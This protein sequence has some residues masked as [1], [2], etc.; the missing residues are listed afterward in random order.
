MIGVME[1]MATSFKRTYATMPQLPRLLYS[2]LLPPWQ[3]TVDVCLCQRLLDT[4]KPV[5]S[6]VG[7]LFLPPG[8]GCAHGFVCALQE[9]VSPVPVGV[10]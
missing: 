5:Q 6:L 9:S 8:S 1:V 10:L 4:H 7:S 3:A 2:V